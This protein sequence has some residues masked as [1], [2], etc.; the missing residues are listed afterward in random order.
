MPRIDMDKYPVVS[1]YGNEY[2]VS[3]WEDSWGYLNVRVYV[4]TKGWLGRTKFKSVQVRTY[5]ARDWGYDFVQIAR[6]AVRKYETECAKEVEDARLR[7]EGIA[8][9]YEWDG[10]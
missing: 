7:R 5:L 4:K 3:M 10:K 9:F 1:E 8:V 6:N 2:Y